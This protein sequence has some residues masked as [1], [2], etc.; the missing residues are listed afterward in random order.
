[1]RRW[2]TRKTVSVLVCGLAMAGIGTGA[3]LGALGRAGVEPVTET[4]P[5][6]PSAIALHGV[7]GP[8]FTISL[9]FADNN[10]S[11]VDLNPGTY[12]LTIDDLSSIH[13]FHLTGPGVDMATTVS[14]TGTS[15][16]TVPLQPGTYTF[17][18]DPH[19]TTMIGTFVVLPYGTVTHFPAST[20]PK[21]RPKRK[22]R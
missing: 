16:W 22:H 2:S 7:V 10:Q 3:A 14:E 20:Q 9:G 21:V 17:V 4:A 19:A 1:M 5:A 15:V 8:G 13:D 6:G 12:K 18:C 11:V